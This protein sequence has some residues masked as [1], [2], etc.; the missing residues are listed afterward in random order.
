MRHLGYS[1]EHLQGNWKGKKTENR[2]EKKTGL[3]S[4]EKRES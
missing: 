2:K 4:E 1:S 3:D